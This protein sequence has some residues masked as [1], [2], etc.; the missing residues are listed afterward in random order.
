MSRPGDPHHGRP[1]R[2][3]IA[4]MRGT[5]PCFWCRELI[6][7]E[8][9]SPHPLSRT[10]E[11][12]V[13]LAEGGALL[14][15]DN[16]APAHRRCNETRGRWRPGDPIPAHVRSVNATRA[17]LVKIGDG[18]Q[19]CAACSDVRHHLHRDRVGFGLHAS[20]DGIGRSRD[21]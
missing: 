7:D 2:R 15:P 14:D 19:F 1:Y 18:P 11:H 8:L 6:D 5:Q 4:S 20:V 16:C 9:P 17:A 21:W 12:I 13:P 3:L 10:V